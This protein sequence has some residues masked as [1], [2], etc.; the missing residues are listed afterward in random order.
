MPMSNDVIAAWIAAGASL[1]VALISLVTT[2]WTIVR[3]ERT[4]TELEQLRDQQTRALEALRNQQA[5]E[6]EQ[7]RSRL[8]DQNDAEK[9][10]R[11]YEYEARKRLYEEHYPLAFQLR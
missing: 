10:K 2:I 5:R 6:L 9:A 11:D 3:G 7:L 8:D 1:V 4:Q